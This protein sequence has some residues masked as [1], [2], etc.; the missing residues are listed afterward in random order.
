MSLRILH[1]NDLHGH[2]DEALNERLQSLRADADI[3]VDSGDIVKAGNLA[4][5]LQREA[6]WPYLEKLRCTASVPGNRESHVLEAAFAKKIEGHTTPLLCANMRHKDGTLVLPDRLIVES[7]NLRIGIF[8]VMVPMVTERM[9]SRAASAFIW[10]APIPVAKQVAS[11]MRP[12]VDLL[13]AL[14]HIG[15]RQDLELAQ[16]PT[17]IDIIFGG[18]SHTVLDEP[19]LHG[20][21]YVCQ[22]GSHG[23]FAG[24]YKWDAGKLT[25]KLV[26]LK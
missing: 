25:G 23:R 1:T 12:N 21:T 13:L 14:T 2:L 5:P 8:G 16:A 9:M 3:Y 7:N 20:S 22:G 10:Q 17:G 15:Y 24:M 11:E 18:H 6:A 19:E 26:P 4:I